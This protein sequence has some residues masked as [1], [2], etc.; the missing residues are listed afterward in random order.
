M[1]NL[2]EWD[3]PGDEIIDESPEYSPK[4]EFSKAKQVDAAVSK[5]IEAR[6]KEM[7]SGYWNLEIKNGFPIKQWIPDSRKAFVSSVI[8]LRSLL[9]PE[10]MRDEKF[11]DVEKKLDEEKSNLFEQ[12]CYKEKKI[13]VK[14]DGKTMGGVPVYV[15][16]GIKIM[17]EIG[18]TVILQNQLQNRIAQPIPGGWD[19]KVNAYWD[20]LV[21][22]YDKMFSELNHVIDRLNYFKQSIN[23][24]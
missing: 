1:T 9:S 15:D 3:E 16:A 19:D 23:Y 7:K 11:K 21:Y 6:A 24:G 10:I 14:Y 5:V 17:P 2:T 20:A 13:E 18:A 12:Y 4:S 8:A 22:V